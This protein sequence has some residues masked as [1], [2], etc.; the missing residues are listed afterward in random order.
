MH[1]GLNGK[2][3]TPDSLQNSV[4]LTVSGPLVHTV[5]KTHGWDSFLKARVP[6]KVFISNHSRVS[7]LSPKPYGMLGKMPDT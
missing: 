2:F 1:V 7:Q 3:L 5:L 4:N 6:S